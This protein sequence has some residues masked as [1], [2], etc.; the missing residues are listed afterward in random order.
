MAKINVNTIVPE[1][2]VVK[3]KADKINKTEKIVSEKVDESSGKQGEQ[4]Q[5]EQE[6]QTIMDNMNIESVIEEINNLN[7]EKEV[8]F[9]LDVSTYA[10]FM[11]EINLLKTICSKYPTFAGKFNTII[12]IENVNKGKGSKKNAKKL[13]KVKREVNLENGF[14]TKKH[15]FTGRAEKLFTFLNLPS[16]D[17]LT[18]SEVRKH[19]FDATEFNKEDGT[20]KIS[21]ELAECL[22]LPNE[23]VFKK[24]EYRKVETDFSKYI[25]N[26]V[27]V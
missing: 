8:N 26:W 22:N 9:N 6:Q 18:I 19:I 5:G 20:R 16:C 21:K 15:P 3:N 12:N 1:N 27:K 24:G 2:K 17:T 13:I 10:S 11:S 23:M 25:L 4:Q 14:Y 7:I